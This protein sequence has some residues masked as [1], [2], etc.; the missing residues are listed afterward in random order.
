MEY[1]TALLTVERSNTDK[2]GL[3]IAEAHRQGIPILPPDVNY[4]G[5]DFTIE[6]KADGPGEERRDGASGS[7]I[8]FG[9][10]AIKNVGQSAVEFLLAARDKGGP[11]KDVDDFCQ[12]V[13]LRQVNRRALECLVKAG[14]LSAFGG[15]AQLLAA[16]DLMISDSQKFHSGIAQASFFDTPAFAAT[17]INANLPQVPEA[18]QKEILAWEKELVGTYVS[19]HPLSRMWADIE[20][21]ITVLTGQIDETMAEQQVTLAG[22]VNFVR[23]IVTKKG[24]PMA[25]AQLE[26][27]QGTIEV[28]IFPRVWEQTKD[29]WEADRILLVRGKVSLRGREPSVLVE[30]ATNQI[31]AV[32]PKSPD[33]APK[34]SVSQG[35]FHLHITVPRSGDSQSVIKRLGQVYELLQSHPGGDRFSLYVEN[36]GRGRVQIDFPNDTTRHSV[37]LEQELRSMLGAGTIRVEPAG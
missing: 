25:F 15:R 17:S 3:L 11:F 18:P 14:A 21:A 12:R 24:E 23:T 31:T 1:V 30:S 36:G 32:V 8:R 4:S 10:A 6:D 27:L 19:E 5:T 29:L 34:R 33:E 26:D 20:K 35:P 37:G 9:L 22:V 28:V 16:V 13:D 7:A 2:V